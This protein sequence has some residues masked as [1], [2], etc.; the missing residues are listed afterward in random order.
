MAVTVSLLLQA[1]NTVC[2]V[3]PFTQLYVGFYTLLLCQSS[4]TLGL[5]QGML[6]CLLRFIRIQI[7]SHD[8][9]RYINLHV[10]VCIRM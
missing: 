4:S 10:Y 6:A 7:R 1:V 8:F 9:W 2:F 3:P 5:H